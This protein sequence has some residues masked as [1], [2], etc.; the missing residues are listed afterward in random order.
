[1]KR[2]DRAGMAEAARQLAARDPDLARLLKDDGVP[3]LWGRKTGFETL[4]RIVLEQQ[5]SLASGRAVYLRLRDT[6][7]TLT[8]ATLLAR[9]V[10]TIRGSGVTRQKTRY[11]RLIAEQIRDGELDLPG[12]SR[13]D[14]DAVRKRLTAITGIGPWTAEVY[15]LMALRRPDAWPA[16]DIA[17]A[18][19]ARGLKGLPERP[20]PETLTRLAEAWRPWRATAAR[21]LWQRYLKHQSGRRKRQEPM[22]PT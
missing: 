3:P 15:L 20:G 19:A 18:E 4:L 13:L 8:S 16:G 2:L 5:V 11:L 10:E 1:M 9:D 6:L 12:L 21:M 7:G 22:F 17:L 14:D